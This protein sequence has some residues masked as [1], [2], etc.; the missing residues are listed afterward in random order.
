MVSETNIFTEGENGDDSCTNGC[1]ESKVETQEYVSTEEECEKKRLVIEELLKNFN[2]SDSKYLS[3]LRSFS[4]TK[5]GL[6]ND[7]IRKRVWPLLLEL[8]LDDLEPYPENVDYSHV[9][10][11]QVVLDVNRSIKRFPPAIPSD[12]RVAMQDQ[13]IRLILKIITK[14]PQLQYYQGYHDVAITFLLVVG[15]TM[16]FHIMEKLSINYLKHFM[17]PTMEKTAEL[18]D[19]IF[20]LLEHIHPELCDYIERAEVGS[21]FALPWFLTWYS[22]TLNNYNDVVRLYDYFLASEP[23]IPLYLIPEIIV[24]RQDIIFQTECEMACL[25]QKL[26]ELPDYLPFDELL[27]KATELYNKYPPHDMEK[28]TLIRRI[29]KKAVLEE[30]MAARAVRR[31]CQMRNRNQRTNR[32]RWNFMQRVLPEW[33]FPVGRISFFVVS[34]SFLA[35][36]YAYYRYSNIYELYSQQNISTK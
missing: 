5:G 9:E 16:A 12:Q 7:D 21:M 22:H 2:T 36:L 24:Y 31:K 25:H 10:F 15:E 13:L 34:A 8:N 1:D 26:S 29:K 20:P 23:L 33:F 3:K 6:I 27:I 18:L 35:G 28:E 11:S 19:Y 4:L 14:H 17:E 32:R 30:K